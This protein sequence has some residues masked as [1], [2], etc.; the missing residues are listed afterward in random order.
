MQELFYE[1]KCF[2]YIR[3]CGRCIVSCNCNKSIGYFTLF[4]LNILIGF[5]VYALPIEK[6]HCIAL[7][8]TYKA[9]LPRLI[10]ARGFYVRYIQF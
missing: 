7:N 6:M 4:F 10:F 2:R 3:I 9:E 5:K 8:C 1:Q